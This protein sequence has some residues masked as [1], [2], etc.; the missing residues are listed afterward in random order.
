M[1]D[2]PSIKLKQRRIKSLCI[3]SQN[4]SHNYLLT[5]SILETRKD[6]FDI[7]FLQEPPWNIVR[8]T[9]STTEPLSDKVVGAP[10]HLEWLYMVHSHKP[11]PRVMTY[12]HS[13]LQ[14][15]CPTLRHNLIN[16]RDMQ[17]LSLHTK[18][19]NTL[20]LLNIYSDEDSGAIKLLDHL[21]DT[22]PLITFMCGDFNC[23]SQIWDTLFPYDSHY[24]NL[25]VEVTSCLGLSLAST[26][27]AQTHFPFN[28]ALNSSMIDLIFSLD[29]LPS[30]SVSVLPE[31]HLSSDHAPMTADLPLLLPEQAMH[32]K[33]LPKN[34][35]EEATFLHDVCEGFRDLK[36]LPSSNITELDT[37]T[38][39][40]HARIVSAFEDNVK[41][42]NIMCH[43][44]LWWNL[45]CSG[46]LAL[47]RAH[48]SKENWSTFRN[49]TRRVK[50][51]FFNEKIE[52]IANLN[53]RPWNLM[54]WVKARKLPAVDTI[55]YEGSPC[56]TPT[57]LWNGLQSMY[58]SAVDRPISAAINN[59]IPFPPPLRV[60]P[61]YLE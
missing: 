9:P 37:L 16:S 3:F 24:A 56:E 12:V 25:L 30:P 13:C 40:L 42:S 44:K 60:D 55:C 41:L 8:N 6:K 38:F 1:I 10:I 22:L 61:I 26:L 14:V 53:R 11:R 21:A 51:A 29:N 5:E 43:S 23:R 57:Q 58:N 34:S 4:V 28:R 33:T 45:E 31:E 17:C 46:S 49:T 36:D 20:F 52:E 7:I 59:Y 27:G 18:D 2:T 47:Y 32:H 15:M 48:R 39:S 35:D 19:S 50:R 54:S